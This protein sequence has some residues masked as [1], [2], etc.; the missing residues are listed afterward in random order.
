MLFLFSL[1]NIS[2]TLF[3][4]LFWQYIES[5]LFGVLS[6]VFIIYFSKILSFF[7]KKEESDDKD[8]HDKGKELKKIPVKYIIE[9]LK[10]W[11][12]YIAF[13]FFYIS[14][15]GFIYGINLIYNISDF[16]E[17]FHYITLSI[18]LIITGIFFFFMKKK[19]ETVFL[20]FR[21]NCI[22]FTVIYSIFLSFFFIKNISPTVFFGINSIFPV[23]TLFSVLIFDHF[24][25]EKKIYLYSL[26]LFYIFLITGYYT[27]VIFPNI[28]LWN[29]SLAILLF[30]MI[31]YTFLFPYIDYFKRF[32]YVS[33]TIGVYLGYIVSFSV[34][35]SILLESF[36]LFYSG[37]L[38]ISIIYHYIVYRF[39]K[40]R[41]SYIIF[42]ITLVFLYIK[43]F[44]L[45]WDSSFLFY[46]VFIFLL[47]YIFI[48]ASYII[49]FRYLSDLYI[50]HIIGVGFSILALVYCFIQIGFIKDILLLSIILFFKSI[51]LFISYIRLKK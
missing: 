43:T 25:K 13:I 30:F 27:S 37:I 9:F 26:L 19:N 20:V 40:N 41:I 51:L 17:I 33:R 15:Y 10:K 35:C 46:I 32:T 24:F 12:Y 18:S 16:S 31:V 39:F 45:F 36:S 21:S 7:V 8:I 5:A 6:V 11:S 49:P 14:L 34:I 42:L 29:I 1:I 44:F 23:F 22:I 47:P 50:L 28:P 3:F 48:G 2:F 4:F 38:G